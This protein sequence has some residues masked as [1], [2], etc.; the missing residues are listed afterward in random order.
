ME[1]FSAEYEQPENESH[2]HII[3]I[4]TIILLLILATS[5]TYAIILKSKN[6]NKTTQEESS[7]ILTKVQN[8]AVP[9]PD[10]YCSQL[11]STPDIEE[12]C[13]LITSKDQCLY[14]FAIIN[15]RFSVCENIE[16]STLKN[17]CDEEFTFSFNPIE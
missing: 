2:S 16:D 4:I 17:K 3:A 1:T 13:H 8:C 12:K 7:A 5:T 14:N 6:L 11:Y 9:S 15:S 10:T